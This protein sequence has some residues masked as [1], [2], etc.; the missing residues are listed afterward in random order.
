MKPARNYLDA[1]LPWAGLVVG[2]VAL[3]VVH[4]F[5]SEGA[6]DDCQ[7]NAPVPVLLIALLGLAACVASGLASWR[8][9]RGSANESRRVIAIM[10]AGLAAL[11][12]FAILLAIVANLVLPPCFQ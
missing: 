7:V 10:S 3:S 2:L 12:T 9:L 8:S 5:G 11:F 1:I 6:F 4:Q